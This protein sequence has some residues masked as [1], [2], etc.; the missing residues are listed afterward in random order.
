MTSSRFPIGV[1]QTASV[2]LARSERLERD[3]ARADHA[4]LGAELGLDDLDT[5][6]RPASSASRRATSSAAGRGQL[7]RGRAEAAADDDQLGVEDVDEGAD[8]GA[9]QVPDAGERRDRA[10][11]RPLSAR[12]TSSSAFA[13]SPHSLSR[14]PIGRTA[15]RERLEV[16]AAAAAALARRPVRDHDHVTEL[17][18]MPRG[19]ARRRGSGRRRRPCR[20]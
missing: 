14:G 6:S 16:A 3:Q 19:R 11:D 2:T 4:G 7:A 20:A 5:A 18:R 12:P 9:E 10:P 8:P 13:P 1:A 17:G 15:G